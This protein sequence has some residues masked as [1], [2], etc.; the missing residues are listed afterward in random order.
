M[1]QPDSSMYSHSNLSSNSLQGGTSDKSR[2]TERHRLLDKYDEYFNPVAQ[3]KKHHYW[4]SVLYFQYK[5]DYKAMLEVA[6]KNYN[7]CKN[8]Y[9]YIKDELVSVNMEELRKILFD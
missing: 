3:M 5:N 8:D 9:E 7:A 1:C 6:T 2:K 4:E